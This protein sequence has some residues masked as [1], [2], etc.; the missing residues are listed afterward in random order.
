MP[1]GL[2]A[3]ILQD[4]QI[5]RDLLRKEALDSLETVICAEQVKRQLKAIAQWVQICRRHG[6]DPRKDWYNMVFQGNP[7][8]GKRTVAQIYSKLL[9]ALD[10]LDANESRIISATDLVA[11]GP[12]AITRLMQDIVEAAPLAAQTAGVLTITEPYQLTTFQKT[13]AGRQAL[14]SLMHGMERPVGKI[15]VVFVGCQEE[16]ADFLRHNTQLQRRI[17]CSINF[18]DLDETELLRIAGAALTQKYGGRMRVEGGLE[19]QYMQV[20]VRRLAHGRVE[21]GFTNSHAVEDLLASI[22]HRHARRLSEIPD[23]QLD[24]SDYFFLSKEDLL[25]PTPAQ[26]KAR[27]E[28]WVA[29]EQLI[30]QD[31]AKASVAEVFDTAEENYWR[32]VRNQRPLPLRLNRIFAGPPGTGKTTVAKLYG[33]VLADLGLLSSGDATVITPAGVKGGQGLSDILHSTVGKTLII[34]DSAISP[35]TDQQLQSRTVILDALYAEMSSSDA[36]DRCVIFTGSESNIDA[37]SRHADKPF[38]SLFAPKII[39]RFEAFTRPQ[40]E[41]IMQRKLQEQDLFVTPEAMQTAM[42]ALEA[43]RMRQSFE[44]ARAIDTL[45]TSANR[46]FEVRTARVGTPMFQSDRMLEPQDVAAN[47]SDTNVSVKNALQDLV[48]DCII[49]DLERYQKEIKISWLMGRDPCERVPCALVF[50]GPCGTGKVTVAKQLA[51]IYYDMGILETDQL[52]ECS[53]TDIVGQRPG[54]TSAKSRAQ[55]DRGLGKVLLVEEAHR[56]VEGETTGELVD[57]FAYLLPKYAS[58]MVVILA[59]P[60]AEMDT[61]L[62][63]RHNLSSLF[64][65]EIIFKNRTPRECIRL[66]DRRLDEEK[67]GGARPFLR[68]PQSP[69]YVEFTRAFQML[70]LYP[71]WSNARDVNVL[72]RWMVSESLREVSLEAAQSGTLELSIT[73]DQAMSCMVRMFN[74]KRDRLKLNQDTK[75]KSVPR[76]LSQPRS[77]SRGSVRFPY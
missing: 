63:N 15:I 9:Y 5:I 12:G 11:E 58:K 28:A 76:M 51:K 37:I 13:Q 31:N 17:C 20:A 40:L 75:S 61:L 46:N 69:D 33:Q 48:A 77:V 21:Q 25:G 57:E 54:E 16:V 18:A 65:E 53:A 43:T 70:M 44:N 30:G 56:L 14:E 29:L 52:A 2:V 67:V 26:I 38:S 35:G 27:S 64:Q 39:V 10:I 45:L 55:L 72:A 1:S 6:E 42:E 47:S 73:A 7:G 49:A 8:T 71:C 62:S 50:K 66:L 19:G 34:N 74:V 32:E 59:G 4:P 3:R 41:Q 68:D 22:S 23:A 36:I 60:Q 24:E